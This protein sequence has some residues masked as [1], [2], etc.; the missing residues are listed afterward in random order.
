MIRL[1]RRVLTHFDY[2]QPVL[3][4]PIIFI[5]F[6][7][8]FE[9]NSY[10]A[11]KQFIYTC[12]G[13]FAFIF[14]FLFPIKKLIWLIPIIYWINIILLLSVDIFGVEK[15]GARRWLE[16]PFTHFTIQPSEIFKPS[17]ML[18]LAYLIHQN[19]PPVNGYKLKQ[20]IKLSFYILSPFFLIA[21]EPDLGTAA[22]LLIVGFGVLFLIGVHYKIWLNIFISIALASPLIYTH[23]LKPYQKQRIH[24]FLS[25]KPSYQVIQSMIAIGNGGLTGKAQEEATQTHFK[26][27]P[28]S[29]SDFI[30]AYMIERFGFL[31]GFVLVSLYI[32]LIMHFLSLIGRLK[33]DYFLKTCSACIA[34]FLFIYTGVNISMVIGFAP[35]V[36]VPLPFFSHG[37]SS[38]VTFMVFFGIMQNLMTFRYFWHD[39]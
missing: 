9:A 22:I 11:E 15:L 29:T 4:L 38:F 17:F 31:G 21:K 3:I 6:F 36:G 30:F 28:I 13:F 34:L 39:K 20:F 37:G 7:L 8:V 5:S 27:L 19:P 2:M 25:E 1:D 32:L 10:L 18:M 12:V 33:D 16:I 23:F 26:F 14:F 35:V 24:D